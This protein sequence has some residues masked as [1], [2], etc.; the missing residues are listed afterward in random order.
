M[1]GELKEPL[2]ELSFT[3]ARPLI[4][5]LKS[6]NLLPCQNYPY[7]DVALD[8]TICLDDSTELDE[9]LWD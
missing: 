8:R 1:Y 5:I 6:M 3:Q 4:S 9:S 2:V 7:D